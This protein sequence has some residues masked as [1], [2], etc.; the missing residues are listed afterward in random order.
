MRA[1]LGAVLLAVFFMGCSSEEAKPAPQASPAAA[2]PSAAPAPAR[3]DPPPSGGIVI[4]GSKTTDPNAGKDGGPDPEQQ[5][6]IARLQSSAQGS[7]GKHEGG[8]AL[9]FKNAL[10]KPGTARVAGSADWTVSVDDAGKRAHDENKLVLACFW[11]SDAGGVFD[12]LRTEIVQTP[13]FKNWATQYVVLL[14]IDYPKA[15]PQPA[16]LKAQNERLQAFFGV[17]TVPTI[18]FFDATG[19][20]YGTLGYKPGGPAPWLQ[21]AQAI[22]NLYNP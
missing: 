4:K 21:D 19:K 11:I 13:E 17:T 14:D 12:K 1:G 7:Q 22:V 6:R 20:V 18:V 9:T 5:E 16:A 2:R 10:P 3:S 15:R 8:D